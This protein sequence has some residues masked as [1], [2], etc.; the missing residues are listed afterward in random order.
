MQHASTG[1]AI[2]ATMQRTRP[3]RVGAVLVLLASIAGG[4]QSYEPKPLDMPELRAA[5]LARTPESAAV[6]VFAESLAP[7]TAQAHAFDPGDGVSC[8]EAELVALVFNADLRVSRLRAG[9]TR[10]SADTAGLWEDPSLGVDL[11]RIIESTPEPWKAFGSLSLTIPIS[12]RMEVAKQHANAAHAA[13]LAR[14]SQQEWG[15]RMEVRRAWTNWSAL[16]AQHAATR[17][18]GVQAGDI[19]ALVAIMEQSGEMARTQA[20]LFRIEQ[21]TKAADLATLESRVRESELRLKR[22]MGLAPHAAVAFHASGIGPPPT[23]E[24]ENG[25]EGVHAA[26]IERSNPALRVARAEH[27]IAE[28]ALELAIRAQYPDLVIGPGFGREDGMDQVLLGLSLPLPIVNGNR[29]AIGEAR[30]RR[31]VASASVE[32][33]LEG[34]MADVQA[35]MVRRAAA[36]ARREALESTIVPLV[37]AQYADARELARL[38]EVNTLVLLESITRQ[39]EAQVAL[40]DARREESLAWIDLSEALGDPHEVSPTVNLLDATGNPSAATT[41]AARAAAGTT[42]EEPR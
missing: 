34:A 8:A 38:G 16:A 35:A 12:G 37:E 40:I 6:R 18:V 24:I 19:L 29:G 9:V 30:A 14:V 28:K 36:T 7:G 17:D 10:A 31:D 15:L 42:A 23:S 20:R 25:E 11:A 27:A 4:C 21:A 32:A 1:R 33:A 13:E 3:A 39:H 2:P 22:L 26:V 5:F 41:Q